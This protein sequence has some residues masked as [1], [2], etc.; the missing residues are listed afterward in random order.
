MLQL[1]DSSPLSPRDGGTI[2]LDRYDFR[3]LARSLLHASVLIFGTAA[4]E[5]AAECAR[6]CAFPG[7]SLRTGNR[8]LRRKALWNSGV[9]RLA[10]AATRAVLALVVAAT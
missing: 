5:R 3:Q 7:I 10:A 1:D 9:Q 6:Q 4:S 2:R 8:S